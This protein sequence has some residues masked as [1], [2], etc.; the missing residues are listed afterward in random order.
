MSAPVQ[1]IDFRPGDRFVV[2]ATSG[3]EAHTFYGPEMLVRF[4]R[5]QRSGTGWTIKH[6]R[7]GVD[8][9][10]PLLF[11]MAVLDQFRGMW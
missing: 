6:I 10:T 5:K 3:N 8:I 2:T 9:S 11:P 4:L 7:M 1:V